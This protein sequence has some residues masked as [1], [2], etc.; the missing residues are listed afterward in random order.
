MRNLFIR[1]AIRIGKS[2]HLRDTL[3]SFSFHT[4]GLSTQRIIDN[5]NNMKGYQ[6]YLIKNKKMP[7]VNVLY[8]SKLKDIFIFEQRKNV[9]ILERILADINAALDEEVFDLIVFDEIGGGELK[10][11]K[12]FSLLHTILKRDIPC[13][14]ILKAYNHC[15][16][17]IDY[18]DEYKEFESFI[19]LGGKIMD[20][21][22]SNLK[23][24]DDEL[25]KLLDEIERK[26]YQ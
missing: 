8:T 5:E 10:S 23:M 7:Q 21:D 4:I 11:K 24:I 20:V 16:L 19:L 26:R 17:G 13:I 15:Q 25:R 9:G 2:T 3:N 22:K 6:G 18:E 14:G 1:G 12:A